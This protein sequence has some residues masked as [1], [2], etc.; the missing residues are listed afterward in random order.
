MARALLG[1]F[2]A[3]APA[4]A[5]AASPPS[6]PLEQCFTSDEII[7]LR[8][9]RE[10]CCIKRGVDCVKKCQEGCDCKRFLNTPCYTGPRA[11]VCSSWGICSWV[12]IILAVIALLLLS[13]C[14]VSTMMTR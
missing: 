6:P 3:P 12:A 7:D 5:P 13:V 1:V 9:S 11:G 14:C 2:A 10:V 4:Q 8:T